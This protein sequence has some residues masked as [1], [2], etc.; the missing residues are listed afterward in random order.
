MDNRRDERI[1]AVALILA[2]VGAVVLVAISWAGYR[3]QQL[4]ATL[5]RFHVVAN[6]DEVE[7]QRQKLVVRDAVL[8]EARSLLAEAHTPTEA[9]TILQDN[10]LLLAQ[11][12]AEALQGAGGSGTV[13]ALLGRADYPTKE[14]GALSLPSGQYTSLRILIG[15]GQGHNW[16]CVLFPD[17][18]DAE[19]ESQEELRATMAQSLSEED[20][21]LLTQ[22]GEEYQLR[23]RCME[24]W[25]TFLAWLR[26]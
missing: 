20:V 26:A 9:Q 16:W 5:V 21:A 1:T 4:A 15:S 22:E 17:L 13:T 23:F 2:L 24:W 14:S 10:L 19:E 6:S 3:Q 11:R 18:T 8:A 7:D 12:G 25:Q